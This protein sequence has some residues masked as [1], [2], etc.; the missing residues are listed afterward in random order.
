MTGHEIVAKDGRY[1]PYVTEVL[2]EAGGGERQRHP[3]EGAGQ[4]EAADRFA[5]QVDDHGDA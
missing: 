1:G 4:A 3:E 2:P 5:V